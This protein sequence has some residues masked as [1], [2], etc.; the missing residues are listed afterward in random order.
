MAF[1]YPYTLADDPLEAGVRAAIAEQ[2][3][4]AR[5]Q[6]WEAVTR[7]PRSE[8]A[9]M[10]LAKVAESESEEKHCLD[11]LAALDPERAERARPEK[12]AK[13]LQQRPESRPRALGAREICER[14]WVDPPRICPRCRC[15]LELGN[16]ETF[17]SPPEH[18]NRK[19]VREAVRRLEL[20]EGRSVVIELPENRLMAFEVPEAKA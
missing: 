1:P 13:L 15:L 10:W 16:A 17:L 7:Q 11:E 20:E 12:R 8:M 18:T 14:P 2:K 19:V 5:W 3:E 4:A 6:L 9:W